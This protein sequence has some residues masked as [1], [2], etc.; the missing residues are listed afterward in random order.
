MQCTF[1]QK[2]FPVQV[3][4][5]LSQEQQ[6]HFPAAQQL[7][8]VGEGIPASDLGS[9]VTCLRH[10][11]RSWMKERAPGPNTPKVSTATGIK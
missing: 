2:K 11:L 5:P 8:F 3:T 1:S 4:F 7:R 6:L 9:P 10:R